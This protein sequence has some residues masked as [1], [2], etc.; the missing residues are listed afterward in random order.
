MD[1]PLLILAIV[2]CFFALF[3]VIL[4]ILFLAQLALLA[5]KTKELAEVVKKEVSPVTHSLDRLIGDVRDISENAKFQL[6]RS[7]QTLEYVHKG[8]LQAT[9]G[10]VKSVSV[11]S[12]RVLPAVNTTYATAYGIY[13]GL[14]F[15]LDRQQRKGRSFGS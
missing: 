3:Q 4:C 1:R 8:L 9:D 7:D 13:K 5:K 11:L 12:T 14:R 6:R 10:V 15:F 2:L